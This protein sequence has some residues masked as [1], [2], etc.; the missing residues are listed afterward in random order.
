[1]EAENKQEEFILPINPELLLTQSEGYQL[2]NPNLIDGLDKD[3]IE[4]IV[5][6]ID[7]G[8]VLFF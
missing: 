4:N 5:E 7:R 8:V 1:M 6:G 3:A 2:S